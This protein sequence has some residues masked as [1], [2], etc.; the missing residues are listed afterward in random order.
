LPTDTLSSSPSSTNSSPIS[1][2][3]TC[4][5]T[6]PMVVVVNLGLGRSGKEVIGMIRI[7]AL[8]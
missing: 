2:S 8:V 3:K 7:F 1:T 6:V 4:R 5:S